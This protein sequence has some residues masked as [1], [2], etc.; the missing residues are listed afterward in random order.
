MIFHRSRLFLLSFMVFLTSS[1]VAET[2][3]VSL[4][5][6]RDRMSPGSN[7]QLRIHVLNHTNE[8]ITSRSFGN[9]KGDELFVVRANGSPIPLARFSFGYGSRSRQFYI[10]PGDVNSRSISLDEL[11]IDKGGVYFLTFCIKDPQS[12]SILVSKPCR[13]VVSESILIEDFTASSFRDLTDKVKLGFREEIGK[14]LAK[15][16]IPIDAKDFS[17]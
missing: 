9:G 8:I 15:A 4:S 2:V 5:I 14:F 12:S 13:F 1:V 17:W 6:R 16:K 7:T 11:G 10:L 3:N